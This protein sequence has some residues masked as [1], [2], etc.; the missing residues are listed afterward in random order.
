MPDLQT[1][2]KRTVGVVF[3]GWLALRLINDWLGGVF[4][5]PGQPFVSPEV[6]SFFQPLAFAVKYLPALASGVWLTIVLTAISITLGFPIAVVLAA[7]RV[8][9]RVT[10]WISLTYIELIR[11]T[12]LLAQLF[13]LYYGLSLTSIIRNLPLVGHG[14]IPAQ[15]FWVAII[16]FTI[17]SSAYQAEY[18][19]GAIQS[20]DLGQLQA[21]RAV[22]LSRT[23]GIRFV[24]LPQAL[25]YA[26]P[27]WTNELV[28]LIKYSSLAAFITVPELFNRIQSIASET[29]AYLPLFTLAGLIYIVLVLTATNLMQDVEHRV[30]IPG[31]N[32]GRDRR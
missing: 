14:I 6:F 23:R 21:A 11:G 7:S 28:Y 29:F 24:V 30:A 25:R 3:W 18:L 19:R 5:Q 9:G 20:V 32:G 22:G 16:G 15:A 8:Y 12:P 26:I 4:V 1:W 2:A 17:N 31:L 10:G 27:S 13:V